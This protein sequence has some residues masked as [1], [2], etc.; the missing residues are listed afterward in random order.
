MNIGHLGDMNVKFVKIR[1]VLDHAAENN[2]TINLDRNCYWVEKS[3]YGWFLR[4]RKCMSTSISFDDL[5][6]GWFYEEHKDI[7][8]YWEE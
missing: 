4:G 3:E 2:E 5:E 8:Y 7:E 6:D 1:E